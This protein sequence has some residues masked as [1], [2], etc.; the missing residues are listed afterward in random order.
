MTTRPKASAQT[1]PPNPDIETR[2]LEEHL[3]M[4]MGSAWLKEPV[5]GL[6]IKLLREDAKEQLAI[7]RRS[8]NGQ[9]YARNPTHGEYYANMTD[10]NRLLHRLEKAAGEKSP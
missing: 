5:K 6:V 8:L 3:M 9:T 4:G 7:L 1:R 10:I 2:T